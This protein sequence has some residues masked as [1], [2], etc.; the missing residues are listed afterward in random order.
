MVGRAVGAAGLVAT[1][2]LG[3]L[4]GAAGMAPA[5]AQAAEGNVQR[6]VINPAESEVVYRVSET[7]LG[8]MQRAVA[9]G[10]TKAIEG[11]VQADPADLRSMSVGTVRVD[12]SQ[13]TSDQPRRDQRIRQQWLESAKYPVSEFTVTAIE[14]LP[15]AF[16]AGEP[17]PVKVHGDLKVKEAVRPV[18]WEGTLA[19][20]DGALKGAF[21][22]EILM[23]DFGFDP[24]SIL[25]VLRA[26]N[27]VHLTFN[28]T[29]EPVP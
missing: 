10:V 16:P 4:L 14:G 11:E 5:G 25:G 13:F 28:F 7:F 19:L 20:E 3:V 1:L 15:E 24:P 27:E 26:D 8:Q 12:I 22:T 6:W 29:A 2:V 17:V 23:T 9:V 21:E 18:V